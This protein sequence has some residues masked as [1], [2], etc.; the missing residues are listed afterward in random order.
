M[1]MARS[2]ALSKE[3][4]NNCE[5]ILGDQKKMQRPRT[6]SSLLSDSSWVRGPSLE[7]E[8]EHTEEQCSG[9]GVTVQ[10]VVGLGA[11]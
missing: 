5:E 8:E 2:R 4:R 11:G 6:A 10:K 3:K 9:R 1:V 7:E